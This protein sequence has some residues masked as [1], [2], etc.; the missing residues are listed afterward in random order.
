MAVKVVRRLDGVE[1]DLV[2]D[3]STAATMADVLAAI[4]LRD[5]A[6]VLVDDRL[7]QAT[8]PLT[9]TSLRSGAVIS[10][11]DPDLISRHHARVTAALV[12]LGGPEAGTVAELRTGNVRLTP[13]PHSVAQLDAG[14]PSL[15][16]ADDGTAVVMPVG[17]AVAVDGVAVTLP[18]PV[19][20]GSVIEVGNQLYRFAAP[21]TAVRAALTAGAVGHQHVAPARPPELEVI[22]PL[23]PL[24]LHRAPE[25]RRRRARVRPEVVQLAQ[26]FLGAVAS[27]R[28]LEIL[29]RRAAVSDPAE[30][31]E[32][33]RLLDP[34]LWS[35]RGDHR[36]VLEVGVAVGTTVWEEL[37]PTQL[38][39]DPELL[40]ELETARLLPW[41]PVVVDLRTAGPLAVIGDRDL[42]LALT[43][44]IVVQL[45]TNIAPSALA[46]TAFIDTDRL[47]DWEWLKWLDHVQDDGRRNRVATTVEDVRTFV[48]EGT[49][50]GRLR[51]GQFGRADEVH[52]RVVIVD[53]HDDGTDLDALLHQ[54]GTTGIVLGRDRVP[55]SCPTRVTVSTEMA[56]VSGHTAVERSGRMVGISAPFALDIARDLSA[57]IDPE[58]PFDHRF[59]GPSLRTILSAE[60]SSISIA[61]SLAA[62]WDRT[63]EPI[64]FASD[65]D[66]SPT[67]RP[68]GVHLYSPD[69]LVAVLASAVAARPDSGRI[70]AIAGRRHAAT[71]LVGPATVV[72]A[73]DPHGVRR[74]LRVLAAHARAGRRVR[75]LLVIDDVAELCARQPGTGD[76]L[77]ELCRIG[78]PLGLDVA[79]GGRP[80]RLERRLRSEIG[81]WFTADDAV[82]GSSLVAPLR[83]DLEGDQRL[84]A[85][86]RLLGA[87][88]T[89]AVRLRTLAAAVVDATIRRHYPP[90]PDPLGRAL[91]DRLNWTELP[92]GAVG[93]LDDLDAGA[94]VPWSWTGQ[95]ALL[96]A[97]GSGRDTRAVLAAVMQAVGGHRGP[98]AVIARA[99]SPLLELTSWSATTDGAPAMIEMLSD[100]D[101]A[102]DTPDAP[103]PLLVIEDLATAVEMLLAQADYDAVD[104]VERIVRDG[105]LAGV[106]IVA[107][108][109]T[110]HRIPARI[111]A[112]FGQRLV[113]GLDDAVD[114]T[115]LGV[116]V[117][118][119]ID[120]PPRRAIDP[121]TGALIQLAQS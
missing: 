92:P 25:R 29:R 4:D 37:Q 94:L 44:W 14:A 9:E 102:I 50:P 47:A 109:T 18:T 74:C 89:E 15:V 72:D 83:I 116:K 111:T 114:A 103:R 35:R 40:V 49:G 52:H 64:P 55:A 46:I 69:V 93:L 24:A 91:P 45:V 76:V 78:P 88:Q 59:T 34:A 13:K 85:P 17:R 100:I 81:Q 106:P 5:I 75:A 33:A 115:L 79:F 65:A 48:G 42:T 16:V 117:G 82:A 30:V 70:V 105:P 28:R 41:T 112:A 80:D 10:P 68:F 54:P 84:A 86:F 96:I 39:G 73:H 56:T 31:A 58:R 118:D 21:P 6:S 7:V 32:R 101:A 66:G 90:T 53:R 26:E 110:L 121:S 63:S 119:V 36:D 11:V 95:R 3:L 120:L 113:L 20:L 98:L 60:R 22:P 104:G 77:V 62:R 51:L 2:L 19:D 1:T 8:T 23:V 108:T 12:H 27:A 71:D 43:R 97:G 61:E 107:A 99:G 67:Y 87:R 57:L 38:T